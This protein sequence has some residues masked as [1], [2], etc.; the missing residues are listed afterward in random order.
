MGAEAQIGLLQ[1]ACA[2]PEDVAA[3][4]GVDD[5]PWET[6]G[7]GAAR[8]WRTVV[9]QLDQGVDVRW[10]RTASLADACEGELAVSRRGTLA[11]AV[12]RHPSTGENITALSLYAA[13]ESVHPLAGSRWIFADGAAHRLVSDLSALVG[14]QRGHRIVAAGDLNILFG[15]GEYGSAYWAGRYQTLFDRLAAIGLHFVGPQFPSGRQADPWPK[16]LP[17]GSRNVPTFRT[18]NNDPASATRQLDFVFASADLAE[19]VSVVALNGDVEWGPS[20]H[21]PL[22]IV[23]R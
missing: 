12:V 8:R 3:R 22:R 16:E 7:P 11:A 23:V 15:Y 19:R 21:C 10:L 5:E 20:D 4:I 2:P 18:R 17:S 6:A 14:S 9:A 1:E 13:W